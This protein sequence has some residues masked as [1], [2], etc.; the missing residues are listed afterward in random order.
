MPKRSKKLYYAKRLRDCEH[1]I[2]KKWNKIKQ[3]IDKT[4]SIN[5][6][7]PK[8]MIPDSIKI[9]NQNKMENGFNRFFMEIGSKLSSF[10]SNTSKDFQ[11]FVST[12]CKV[13]E[14]RLLQ[15]RN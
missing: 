15:D 7:V 3:V 14:E 6:S 4:K 10:I 9:F 8:R 1:H 12:P 13:L 2:K 11:N 5:N